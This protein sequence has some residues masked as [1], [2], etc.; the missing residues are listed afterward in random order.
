MVFSDQP[1]VIRYVIRSP[2]RYLPHKDE[3]EKFASL[4]SAP[5]SGQFYIQFFKGDLGQPDP[6]MTPRL[7]ESEIIKLAANNPNIQHAADFPDS[8]VYRIK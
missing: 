8:I 6:Y 2:I 4:V 3:Y 1:A 5:K 7:S